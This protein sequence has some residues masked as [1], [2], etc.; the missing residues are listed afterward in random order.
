MV[1]YNLIVR[2]YN[3]LVLLYSNFDLK[4]RHLIEGRRNSFNI[5]SQS[6]EKEARI[7]WFH[8]ASLGE[9]E[10][11]LPVMEAIRSSFPR[12]RLYISFFSPS[13]YE[14]QQNNPIA[15]CVFYLPADTRSNAE[16][17]LN[18]LDPVAAFFIKYEFWYNY[19]KACQERNIP[20]F[21]ISTILRPNQVFFKSYGGFYRKT[22]FMFQ[23]FFVQNE[24]TLELI[25]Q[26][27]LTNASLSGDTRF[28]RVNAI[29]K[30][31]KE[32]KAVEE[33]KGSKP[34]IVLGSTWKPDIELW[35]GY[36]NQNDGL[37]Y[38]IAPH[39]IEEGDLHH[40]EEK[41]L[42]N[43]LRYS[44][45]EKSLDEIT[46]LIIDNIG[47]LSALYRYADITYV[48]G[49]FSE[50]LHNILEPATY[51]KPIIIGKS[52]TNKK[53]REVVSLVEE[54]GAFEIAGSA[55]LY[56]LMHGLLSNEELYTRACNASSAFVSNNLGSTDIIMKYLKSILS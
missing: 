43:T 1:I 17:L 11:G 24:E 42:V 18:L 3:L 47:M 32:F 37:K 39:N 51:G 14:V 41:L 38:I 46:V 40:I 54:G 5:L 8:C 35:S 30:K 20:V 49:A 29:L 53:Y 55:D 9:F 7:L 12:Y 36:I 6:L 45:K 21:S 44:R 34:L 23:H 48:G 31:N 56:D 26:I 15:D 50:G 2:A 27:G 25:R 16:K 10:Q 4:A 33:F 52:R 13:G 28:D 19:L 22:L